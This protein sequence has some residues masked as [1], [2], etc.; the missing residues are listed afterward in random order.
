MKNNYG[1]MVALLE[2]ATRHRKDKDER[3]RKREYTF[4]DYM[5]FKKELEEFE[6]WEKTAL[7]KDIKQEQKSPVSSLHLAMIL[8]ASFPITA[9]L[10]VWWIKSFLP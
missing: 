3:R 8:I 10:Y 4:K 2:W 5:K 1:D 9:P 7:K 6:K